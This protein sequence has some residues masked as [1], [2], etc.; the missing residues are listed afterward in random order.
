MRKSWNVEHIR[1]LFLNL[2]SKLELHRVVLTTLR[3]SPKK[4]T[5]TVVEMDQRFV[6][7]WQ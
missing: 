7:S 4:F 5:L 3:T 2:E 6:R 1:N